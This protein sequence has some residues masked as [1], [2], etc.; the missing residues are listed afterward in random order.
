MADGPDAEADRQLVQAVDRARTWLEARAFDVYPDGRISI[1][2]AAVFLGISR[3]TLDDYIAAG[4]MPP[5]IVVSARVR[6]F[7]LPDLVRWL[8]GRK[9]NSGDRWK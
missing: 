6:Y 3:R 5:L 2:A 4:V 9:R 7:L 1:R 8:A